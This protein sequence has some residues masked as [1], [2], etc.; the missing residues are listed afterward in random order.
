MDFE[1]EFKKRIASEFDLNTVITR[2]PQGVRV[3]KCNP[4]PR[5][6]GVMVPGVLCVDRGNWG[7]DLALCEYS[8]LRR[9]FWQESSL[10]L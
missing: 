5:Q 10:I 4:F 2:A 7:Q 3:I 6:K 1:N 9:I 8:V